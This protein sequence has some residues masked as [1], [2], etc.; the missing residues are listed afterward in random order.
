MKQEDIE[1]L[2]EIMSW[3]L[4]QKREINP[5]SAEISFVAHFDEVK[6]LVNFGFESNAKSGTTWLF[7]VCDDVAADLLGISAMDMLRRRVK[8]SGM[9]DIDISPVVRVTGTM[10]VR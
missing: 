2:A 3:R 7:A 8:G 10:E 4:S 6:G 1:A 5:D 9:V